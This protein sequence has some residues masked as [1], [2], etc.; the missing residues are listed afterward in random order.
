MR[1][2]RRRGPRANGGAI[3]KLKTWVPRDGLSSGTMSQVRALRRKSYK[4]SGYTPS[5]RD[6]PQFPP[7]ARRRVAD[8]AQLFLESLQ[9]PLLGLARLLGVAPLGLRLFVGL[10]A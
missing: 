6:D 2:C 5:L 10:F 9:L 3:A 1:R 8:D 7:L 4:L